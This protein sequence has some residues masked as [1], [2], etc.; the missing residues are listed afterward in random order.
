MP[1]FNSGRSTGERAPKYEMR[2]LTSHQSMFSCHPIRR[3]P[4]SNFLVFSLRIGSL[5]ALAS[6]SIRTASLCVVERFLTGEFRFLAGNLRFEAVT[7]NGPT[8][9]GCQEKL[10]Q[11]IAHFYIDRLF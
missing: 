8:C 3:R 4:R 2:R 7:G 11:D 6:G 1:A 9:C 10:T 5:S